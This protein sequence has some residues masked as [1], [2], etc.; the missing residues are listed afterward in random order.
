MSIDQ[1][2]PTVDGHAL[3]I[4]FDVTDPALAPAPY[5]LWKRFRD[6]APVIRSEALG[7]FYVV[8]RYSD[9]CVAG[10]DT[11]TFRSYPSSAIPPLPWPPM[12]PIEYDNP[13]HHKF[14]TVINPWLSPSRVREHEAWIQKW[15]R[16]FTDR[17]FALE[18]FDFAQDFARPYTRG[19]ALRFMGFPENDEELGRN[20]DLLMAERD[21]SDEQVAAAAGAFLSAITSLMAE[22]RTDPRDDLISGLV[23]ARIDGEPISDQEVMLSTVAVALGGLDTTSGALAAAAT[24]LM[25][26]PSDRERL[27]AEPELLDTAVEEFIRWA[28]ALTGTARTVSKDTEFAGCPMKKGDRVWLLW[29]SGSRD[30]SAFEDPEN[31]QLDRR[32]N[33]HLGF[34][35]GPHRCVGAHV[36]KGIMR[37]ALP[38]ILE[39]IGDFQ[40]SDPARVEWVARETRGITRLPLSRKR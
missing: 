37:A 30:E 4:D 28:A 29:G 8:S 7:G 39:P 36:A 40:I 16:S 33:R 13:E 21:L 6:A 32:P 2:G 25:D 10:A 11:D 23:N 22:R 5:Q 14:R 19:V 3:G 24:Y 35:L 20:I 18:E 1:S 38:E 9:L 31:V 34:G 26:N 17:L 15:A 12:P 27:I